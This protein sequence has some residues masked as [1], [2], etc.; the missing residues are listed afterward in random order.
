ML[1]YALPKKGGT[2][3]GVGVTAITVSVAKE[4]QALSQPQY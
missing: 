2:V 3:V 4:A 1:I